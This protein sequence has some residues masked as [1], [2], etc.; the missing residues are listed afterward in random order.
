MSLSQVETGS[1]DRSI[2][3]C[4]TFAYLNTVPILQ[5]A[6]PTRGPGGSSCAGEVGQE[7]VAA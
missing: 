3:G 2:D 1:P 6:W 7:G 5:L 4:D